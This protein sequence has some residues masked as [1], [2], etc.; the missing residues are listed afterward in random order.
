MAAWACGAQAL[1]LEAKRARLRSM[2]EQLRLT[3][4]AL[5]N[6]PNVSWLL[7]G[8]DTHVLLSTTRGN[9]VA[10]YVAER[11]RVEVLTTNNEYARLIEEEL[12]S[13]AYVDVRRE[14]TVLPWYGG[15][16]ELAVRERLAGGRAGCDILLE[17]AEVQVLGAALRAAQAPLL[18][19]EV[20][21]YRA[22]SR[23]VA[24]AVEE[25][26]MELSPGV[27][28]QE[29]AAE[30]AR[31]FLRAG[32]RPIVLLVGADERVR[33]YRHP[34]PTATKVKETLMAAVVGE[35]WGLHACVTRMVHFGRPSPELRRRFAAVRHVFAALC[36]AAT[37]GE[38]YRSVLE[39]AK[40]AYR[41]A[42]FPEEWREHHQG[43]LSGYHLPDFRVTLEEGWRVQPGTVICWNPTIAGVKTEDTVLV[44]AD[45]P[46]LLSVTERW[47]RSPERAFGE[48]NL[49]LPEILER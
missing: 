24:D 34:I 49:V 41:E 22:L 31:R 33:R 27:T 5:F 36:E 16:L 14:I 13:P 42:G 17:G 1:E 47:P 18:D 46:E 28:E 9:V 39:A 2:A 45:G 29:V 15:S 7:G 6:A 12:A 38:E 37:P 30:V 3:H 23:L 25:T 32:V 19:V 35:R 8:I 44:R 48:R 21:R 40:K 4:V 11:D 26:L 20:E 10:L 43:G